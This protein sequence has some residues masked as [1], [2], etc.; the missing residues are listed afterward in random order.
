MRST[1]GI[2]LKV[3]LTTIIIVTAIVVLF[4]PRTE[5]FKGALMPAEMPE[6]TQIIDE[7]INPD[8]TNNPASIV[9]HY[10]ENED[11]REVEMQETDVLL[12]GAEVVIENEPVQITGVKF[13][14]EGDASIDNLQLNINDKT[15]P[16]IDF[17]FLDS[18]T[19]LADLSSNQQIIEDSVKL[20]LFGDVDQGEAGDILRIHMMDIIAKGLMTGANIT[21]IG[22]NGTADPSPLTLRFN[23]L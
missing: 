4:L 14:L 16:D 13:A 8:I 21:N 19:L 5:Y 18:N 17:M 3:T 10:I 11:D 7:S 22:I 2:V 23:A 9:F 15:V 6:R 12:F 20:E 1:P